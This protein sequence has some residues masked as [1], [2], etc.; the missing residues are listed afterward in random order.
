MPEI[1]EQRAR[2]LAAI[3]KLPATVDILRLAKLIGDAAQVYV[4]DAGATSDNAVHHEIEGLL[5][6]ADRPAGYR[7]Y[8]DLTK[9]V[10]GMSPR[11]QDFLS[12]RAGIVALQIPDAD[13]FSDPAQRD[14]ACETIR[15]LCSRGGK[16]VEGRRPGTVEW[17]PVLH[18]P[19]K[20]EKHP[21]RRDAERNFV[22]ALQ[23]IYL[24][25][26]G[27]AP[28]RTAD[29]GELPGP[30]ARLVQA[31]FDDLGIR[32]KAAKLINDLER[33]RQKA[34]AERKSS[35]KG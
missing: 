35:P 5:A 1:T 13:A 29:P 30:F 15:R 24:E 6:A 26:K 7:N 33:R 28:A 18:V 2:E 11:T 19:M 22:R 23:L 9:R 12:K 3:A 34:I 25:M 21:T 17:K 14:D 16:W 4:R 27:R 10:T 20:I 31:C 32:A 8:K